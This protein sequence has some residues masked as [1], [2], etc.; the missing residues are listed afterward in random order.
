MAR[1]IILDTETT[2][3][4]YRTGHRLIEIA[5][6]E[7]DDFIPTGRSFHRYVHPERDIEE[8]AQKVHGISIDFLTGKPKFAEPHVCDEF[9]DFVSD[10]GIIA[11][12]APFD[13][14][15]VNFELEKAG[16]TVIHEGRWIDTLA[17]AQKRFP[18]MYNSLDALCKRFRISLAEREKHGALIDCRL[19]AAVYLE[20]RGG[21]ERGLDLPPSAASTAAAQAAAQVVHGVRPRPL[22]PRSTEQERAAHAAFI[23]SALKEKAVWL[24]HGLS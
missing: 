7:L 20:L 8:G 2:G 3:L 1:E 9:L 22:A 12:N 23:T 21:K 5:C 16:R 24:K 15:F 6:I 10:C 13:R 11:H 14:G 4:D 18:G 19:L 17:M